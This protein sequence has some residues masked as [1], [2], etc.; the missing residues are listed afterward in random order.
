MPDFLSQ[1]K[2]KWADISQTPGFRY[3][4]PFLLFMVGGSLALKEFAQVRYQ[5]RKRETFS[6]MDFDKEANK[7]KKQVSL[8]AEFAKLKTKVE[9]DYEMIRGPREWEPETIQ[10]NE[11]RRKAILKKAEVAGGEAQAS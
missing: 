3:G 9:D 6:V 4:L 7:P 10:E 11:R 5:F 2:A 1:W 8:E